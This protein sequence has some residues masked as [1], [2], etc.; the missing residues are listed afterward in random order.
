MEQKKV[1]LADEN[2][3][4]VVMSNGHVVK[5]RVFKHEDIVHYYDKDVVKKIGEKDDEFIVEKQVTEYDRCNR[6]DYINSHNNDVGVKNMIAKAIRNGESADYVLNEKFKSNQNGFV[7]MVAVEDALNDPDKFASS[8]QSTIKKLP[9]DLKKSKSIKEISQMSESD[10]AKYVDSAVA[11]YFASK[12]K[13][14]KV[15]GEIKNG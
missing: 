7:D 15:E 6:R 5:K 2:G 3:E 13:P 1:N 10:I 12:K 11:K 8:V 4:V 14:E 9:K